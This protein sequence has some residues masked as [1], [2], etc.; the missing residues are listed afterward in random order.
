MEAKPRLALPV[1]IATLILIPLT[2]T[3]IAEEPPQAG[4]P[5]VQPVTDSAA[6]V[7]SSWTPADFASAIPADVPQ[8]Q[9]AAFEV[10]DFADAS[11]SA[12]KGDFLVRDSTRLPL[13]LH[14]KLFFRVGEQVFTCSGTVVSSRYGNAVYTAGHCVYDRSAGRFVSD[15]IFAPAYTNRT[16]PLGFYAASSRITTRQWVKRGSFA[17]DI[18]MVTLAGTP[19]LN[20]GGARPV[21]F[22]AN[23]KKRRYTLYGYPADPQPI[24][25][26]ENLFGCNG[27]FAGRDRG[28]PRTIAV[29]PCYMGQGASGG[30][31]MSKG[32]LN[33]VTSY[34]YCK[35]EPKSCGYLFAPYFAKSAR[36]LYTSRAVGGSITPTIAVRKGPARKITKRRAGFRFFGLASTPLTYWCKLDRRKFRKCRSRTATPKL[37][38][39]RHV[40]KVKAY[41]QTGRRS[42]NT[43]R[44]KFRVVRG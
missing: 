22:N 24:F 9:G 39:G 44:R 26:G 35:T 38:I 25:N 40:F 5:V 16:F 7:K 13:R 34:F 30:A 21:T 3:A 19:V 18:A 42:G 36:R 27:R 29:T 8:P 20:L 37:S 17:H 11:V 12:R 14:G 1:L 4:Q 15:L 32:Y 41:D 10:P 23:P 31:W 43:I 2:G 6:E 33:A 28:K